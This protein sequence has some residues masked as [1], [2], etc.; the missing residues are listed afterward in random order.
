MKILLA[1][2][3]VCNQLAISIT[4]F[5]FNSVTGGPFP[6]PVCQGAEAIGSCG[7]RPD[8]R[9]NHTVN[10]IMTWAAMRAILMFH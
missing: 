6:V 3:Y 5:E 2:M 4:E 1:C 10:T 7:T 8:S 9:Y